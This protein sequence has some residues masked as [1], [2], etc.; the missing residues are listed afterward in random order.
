MK[1]FYNIAVAILACLVS[2]DNHKSTLPDV[3]D[4]IVH[5]VETGIV[6]D[7]TSNSALITGH[8]L[9]D[10]RDYQDVKFGILYSDNKQDLFLYKGIHTEATYLN[11]KEFE[12]KIRYLTP[13]TTYYY[14]AWLL[15]NGVQ[16]EYG[17]IKQFETKKGKPYAI[18]EFS[19]SHLKKVA[20]SIGNL[21]YHPANNKWRFAENQTDYI[22]EPNCNI[23]STYRGWIDL[24]GWSSTGLVKF[25]VSNSIDK[26]DYLGYFI[27]WGE[28]E[29]EGE[30]SNTWRTLSAEEWE[31]L[32]N[33]RPNASVLYGIAQVAGVN[34]M[35][36]LPD[37]WNVSNDHNF[38]S[39]LYNYHTDD[40]S[41]YQSITEEQ[42]LLL[43]Q[44]GAVFLPAAY[45]REGSEVV[46]N[47]SCGKGSYWSS[48]VGK[49]QYS[50]KNFGFSS[51]EKEI[52]DYYRYYG[53]SARLVKDL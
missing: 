26:N 52:G 49:S 37:Y 41:D 13:Q 10:L 16:Y 42:W 6:T 53:R 46:H 1:N 27:D 21:Q 31:F 44:Y 5:I 50:A 15:L 35:I 51:A 30:F 3:E 12:M 48:S 14:C 40:F 4:L 38:K 29:I 8:V 28:N 23:S 25:G 43:E 32:I 47:F 7:I 39:G 36:I 2:C 20:F 33:T 17:D 18:G 19:V 34:G 11:G 9:I 24:F 45:A 22:G